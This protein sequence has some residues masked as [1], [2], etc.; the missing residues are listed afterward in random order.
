MHCAMRSLVLPDVINRAELQA[1]S[2][3]Q[4]EEASRRQAI[5]MCCSIRV[6]LQIALHHASCLLQMYCAALGWLAKLRFW[7][8]VVISWQSFFD[9]CCVGPLRPRM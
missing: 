4:L 6:D 5:C 9:C 7:L 8:D 2:A 3:G 1:A